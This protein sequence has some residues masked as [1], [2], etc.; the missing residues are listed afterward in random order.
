VD[1][2]PVDCI[3]PR[4]DE[5]AFAAAEMLEGLSQAA[6][7][8]LAAIRYGSVVVVAFA[9][10][11]DVAA[12]LT[13][14][15]GFVVTPGEGRLLTACSWSSRVWPHCAPGGELVVRCHLHAERWPGLLEL[16][17]RSLLDAVRAELRHLLGIRA[18]P[19]AERVY[20][21][22]RAMPSYEVGH[23]DRLATV[24]GTLAE[25]P[26]LVLAG[27]GYRGIGVLECMRQ[28]LEAATRILSGPGAPAAPA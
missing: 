13:E 17:N 12:S 20:R 26:G 25:F 27:A 19:H 15:R 28:G 6:A 24:T 23:L 9:F 21:W 22:P 14:G 5:P 3:H 4:K 8:E 7:A 10:E 2:C 18:E 11:A 1:V 16:D